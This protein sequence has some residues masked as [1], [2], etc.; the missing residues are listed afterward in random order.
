VF[1]LLGYDSVQLAAASTWRLSYLIFSCLPERLW[2]KLH[3]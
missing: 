2:R 3:S 1:A